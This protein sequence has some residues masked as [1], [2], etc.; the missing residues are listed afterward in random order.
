MK[1]STTDTEL[2]DKFVDG[3]LS[4]YIDEI[5]LIRLYGSRA[6]GEEHEES[7]YDL[8]ILVSTKRDDLEKGILEVSSDLSLGLLS[9]MVMGKDELEYLNY[10]LYHLIRNIVLDGVDIWAQREY[11]EDYLRNLINLYEENSKGMEDLGKEGIL[12]EIQEGE[13]CLKASKVLLENDL[14]PDSVAKSYFAMFHFAKATLIS[15]KVE[16]HRHSTV[17]SAFGE[18]LV[19]PGKI[20]KELGRMLNIALDDRRKA[21]YQ[22]TKFTSLFTEEYTSKRLAEAEK[23]AE[24]VNDYLK[25]VK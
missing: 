2:L 5:E 19:K 13:R 15:E 25:E 12:E 17:V 9:P 23:F 21:D 3:I 20:E 7:D 14:Y 16:R 24:T 1:L 10:R 6:R 18:M 11:R 8:F 4:K 22:G